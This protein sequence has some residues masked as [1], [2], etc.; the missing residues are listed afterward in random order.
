[1]VFTDEEHKCKGA[2]NVFNTIL[3]SYIGQSTRET[4][5]YNEGFECG[6]LFTENDLKRR[7]DQ[8]Q[9]E[10]DEF[11][12]KLENLKNMTV[13]ELANWLSEEELPDEYY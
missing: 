1:M 11:E 8:L 2:N 9:A 5:S 3:K 6:K 13:L 10:K 4:R 7:E 12:E